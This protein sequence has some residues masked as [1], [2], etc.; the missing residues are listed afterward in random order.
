MAGTARGGPLRCVALAGTIGEQVA[1]TIHE[2]R[3]SPCRDFAPSHAQGVHEPRCDE[4]RG[5]HGLP[6][7]V[8]EDWA[9]VPAALR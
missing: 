3:P 8:P 1:C 2:D 6:P 9:R 5:R 7:L 4:A